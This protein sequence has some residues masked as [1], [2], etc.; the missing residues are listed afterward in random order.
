MTPW[1]RTCSRWCALLL[2]LGG[3]VRTTAHANTVDITIPA[4]VTF[5]VTDSNASS[6]AGSPSPFRISYHSFSAP[7]PR[8]LSIEVRAES[9][10]FTPVNGTAIPVSKV[11]WTASNAIGGTG[12]SGTLDAS[13]Y[14][15]VYLSTS[16]STSGQV[17]LNWNLST[18][19][20]STRAGTYTAVLRWRLQVVK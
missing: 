5:V 8:S 15:M 3:G 16:T 6:T 11:T 14:R 13:T 12:Y 1:F 18:V 9:I 2:V 17:D 20:G 19:G 4:T 10:N 7:N